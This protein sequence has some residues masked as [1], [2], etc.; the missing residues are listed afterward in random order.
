MCVQTDNENHKEKTRPDGCRQVNTAKDGEVWR[1]AL[2][3]RMQYAIVET[4]TIDSQL[5]SF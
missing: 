1:G 5:E 3:A 4:L 2:H